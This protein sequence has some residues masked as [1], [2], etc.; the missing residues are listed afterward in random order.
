MAKC[1]PIVL[2]N[3]LKHEIEFIR[4]RKFDCYPRFTSNYK[5][6]TLVFPLIFLWPFEWMG[7]QL[8]AHKA[9]VC[10]THET[11]SMIFSSINPLECISMRDLYLHMKQFLVN[12]YA[13]EKGQLE[14]IL[15]IYSTRIISTMKEK[16]CP[17]Y[18]WIAYEYMWN[19][20]VAINWG[21]EWTPT[22]EKIGI[23]A[24]L[25]NISTGC[26]IW[27]YCWVRIRLEFRKFRWLGIV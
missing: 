6:N 26:G 14:F 7:G 23:A 20:F 19:T 18:K 12:F 1:S 15:F 27:I 5:L 16:I 11:K 9:S 21:I 10:G 4:I 24:E 17:V 2:V 3:S 22:E 13:N 8:L 25:F